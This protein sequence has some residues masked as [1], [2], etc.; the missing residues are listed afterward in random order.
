M[1][2]IEPS[3]AVPPKT[4]MDERRMEYIKF[5][6]QP[7]FL[8]NALNLIQIKVREQV[9]FAD[10]GLKSLSYLYRNMLNYSEEHVISLDDELKL[11]EE[12][13]NLFAKLGGFP[14]QLFK[15]IKDPT[16]ILTVPFSLLTL[17]ENCL[18]HNA[19]DH[20][21]GLSIGIYERDQHLWFVNNLID[22][23]VGSLTGSGKGLTLLKQQF[24][25]VAGMTLLVE[26]S[27]DSFT[28]KM[29]LIRATH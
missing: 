11:L 14:L 16:S 17:A 18:K 20:D 9:E 26:W 8:F 25:H 22:G 1:N 21:H 24:E 12:Y 19:Y 28:V 4:L 29:P 3:R 6:M 10:F 23:E 15:T 7:H 13:L 27:R 2:A 5:Q